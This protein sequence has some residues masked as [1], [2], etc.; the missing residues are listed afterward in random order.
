MIGWF[1]G[2][3]GGKIGLALAG[4]LLASLIG[5]GL[6]IWQWQEAREDVGRLE[7]ELNQAIAV[8]EVNRKA[9]HA[10]QE[11]ARRQS[12]R[13]LEDQE[14]MEALVRDQLE[15]INEIANSEDAPS[16]PVLRDTFERLRERAQGRHAD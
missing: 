5:L 3:V 12:Q 9:L 14:R 13:A 1:T 15:I 11:T 8:A 2:L 6:A 10:A 4:G 7:A 16:A